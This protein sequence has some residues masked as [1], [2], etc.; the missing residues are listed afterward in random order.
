MK[1]LLMFISLIAAS[2]VGMNLAHAVE[3]K[4]G[5][6]APRSNIKTIKRWGDMGKYIEKEMGVDVKI[7]P[8]KPN[9]AMDA[10]A[11]GKVDYVLANPVLTIAMQEKLATVPMVTMKTK[12]GAQFAGVIIAKEGS[13][14][15][16]SADLKGKNVMGYKF[17]RSAAAYVF[18][19]K[20]MMD[21]G[22]DP[23]KD[24]AQFTE[25]K[26][27]DDIVF[28]VKAGKFDG[29]FIKSG[30]LEFMVKEGRVKLS[31][32]VI[33]DQKKDNLSAV[34][35][36]KLY[37][38]WYIS[39]SSSADKGVTSK[40]KAILL[41]LSPDDKASKKAKIVGFVAPLSLTELKNTLK[42]LKLPPYD[43]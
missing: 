34:H 3:I 25:A 35:T 32:F 42:T 1:K 16:K 12:S 28:A 2:L 43:K 13:G 4:V 36:T 19:V 5:V 27:Q 41:K 10:V 30:L 26:N 39:S 6:M 23:H 17:K 40:L 38:S 14:I 37:P 21:N 33:V 7:I 20:H 11:K 24:F 29:G 8:L 15:N 31:D 9:K 18:Q 22:V